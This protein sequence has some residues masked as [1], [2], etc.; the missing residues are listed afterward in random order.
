MGRASVGEVLG[1][2]LAKGQ[3][4]TYLP[5]LGDKPLNEAAFLGPQSKT[6]TLHPPRPR[7]RSGGEWGP[8][9]LQ[10]PFHQI[11]FSDR[12]QRGLGEKIKGKER[13]TKGME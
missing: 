9:D 4:Q 8:G 5:D 7:R 13:G 12:A 6:V 1:E 10:P 3:S 11:P 2:V